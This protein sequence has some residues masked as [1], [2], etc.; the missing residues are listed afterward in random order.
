MIPF[1]RD[2]TISMANVFQLNVEIYALPFVALEIFV[3]LVQAIA[4]R[5]IFSITARV[6]VAS[7]I[8]LG[9]VSVMGFEGKEDTILHINPQNYRTELMD[10][11]TWQDLISQGDILVIGAAICYTF[12][13]IRLEPIA[14]QTKAVTLAAIKATTETLL[15]ILFLLGLLMYQN[16]N[17]VATANDNYLVNF[18]LESAA[19]ISTFFM[20]ISK[21]FSEGF[22]PT[23]VL[24]P[25][26]AACLWTG[27]ITC[28]YTIYAQ[29][30]GQSRVSPADANLIYTFQPV[31]TSLI[32]FL[33]LGE[34]LGPAGFIGGSL[35]GLAIYLVI[36]AD[37]QHSPMEASDDV[38]KGTKM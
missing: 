7:F 3:P 1:F 34:T 18:A 12:H 32:A 20:T 28:G 23:S 35:I 27:T 9:G 8:A 13:C 19:D 5:D 15:S 2:F 38:R 36:S 22:I 6:W 14:K 25:A 11:F 17:G 24:L 29:S 33:L 31:W 10:M 21:Q 16:C 37:Q 30:Y 26:L 4:A